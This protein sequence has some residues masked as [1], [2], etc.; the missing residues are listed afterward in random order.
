MLQHLADQQQS[1]L[2]QLMA[3]QVQT[4]QRLW[5][6]VTQAVRSA[7]AGAEE[8]GG[9]STRHPMICIPKMTTEDDPETF[10]NSFECSAW[11]AGWP[12]K[13]QWAAI[14]IQCLVSSAQQAVDTLAPEEVTNY[15][16]VHD[17]IFQTLN[18]SP[19]AYRQHLRVVAIGPGYHPHFTAQKIRAANLCWLCHAV[20]TTMQVAEA[21]LV[22]LGHV[23][24]DDHIGGGGGAYGSICLG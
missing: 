1:M 24:P 21:V 10:L 14:L 9:D 4:N 16:Q 12:E 7:P 6:N 8:G 17:A 23:P 19:E 13:N 18:L 20:Q 2:D 3:A 15:G 11:A 5:D 22:K